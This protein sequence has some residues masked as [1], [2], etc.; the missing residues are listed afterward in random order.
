M[1]SFQ[2]D[3]GLWLEDSHVLLPWDARGEELRR[4]GQPIVSEQSDRLLLVWKECTCLGGLRCQ[5]EAHLY[6]SQQRNEFNSVRALKQL[7][8]TPLDAREEGVRSQYDNAKQ[9]LI[10]RL[11]EPTTA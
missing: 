2:L 5:V 4:I 6:Y 9:H 8:L 3:K 1:N 7:T 10:E 11:G